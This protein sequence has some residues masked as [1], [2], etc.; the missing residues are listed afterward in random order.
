ML[1]L[2]S[3]RDKP[4]TFKSLLGIS[5]QAVCFSP[6]PQDAEWPSILLPI[7]YVLHCRYGIEHMRLVAMCNSLAPTSLFLASL[8]CCFCCAVI[9]EDVRQAPQEISL[10]SDLEAMDDPLVHRLK[11]GGQVGRQEC[12]DHGLR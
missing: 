12:D 2:Q 8:Q 7:P 9:V 10:V 4:R 5:W 11:A 3:T 1:Q 6:T